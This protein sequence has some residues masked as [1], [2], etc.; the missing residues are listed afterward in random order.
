MA[1]KSTR[2]TL[3]KI[4]ETLIFKALTAGVFQPLRSFFKEMDLEWGE[5][6]SAYATRRNGRA[7][8]VLGPK[9]FDE[10][11]ENEGEAAEVVLHEIMHH[12][13]LHLHQLE[14]FAGR[15]Y[16]HRIQNIAMDAVI[17]AYLSSIKCA[18]FMERYYKDEEEYAF[19]RPGSEEF[20]MPYG[21]GG[22]LKKPVEQIDVDQYSSFWRFY[23]ELYR[24]EVKLEQSLS[25][26]QRH[27][28]DS[29]EDKN[30]QLLG[31]HGKPSPDQKQGQQKPEAGKQ[32]EEEKKES[33][34][35]GEEKKKQQQGSPDESGI[36]RSEDAEQILRD[37]GLKRASQKAKDNFA[38]VIKKIT[39]SVRKPGTVRTGS[40]QSRRIP[41]KLGRR[42]MVNVERGRDL[43]GRAEY[44]MREAMLLF[45]ISGSMDA[46]R[47]FVIDLAKALNRAEVKVRTAVWADG[48]QEVS[49]DEFIAGKFPD[50]GGGTTGEV[51]AEFIN[52]NKIPQAAII[53]DNA[54][55][56]IS[57]KIS[58]KIYLCLV[59]GA[60]IEGSFID[61]VHVPNC[62]VYHLETGG[63]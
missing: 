12:L 62:E 53:T 35:K 32:K 17:N 50:V 25:F 57:T 54:A 27:F 34:G 36:F 8:I 40:T 29:K 23:R 41:A 3:E 38:E 52:D 63:R 16:S 13:F 14:E 61:P 39:T 45:D 33:K 42:D 9:F 21:P 47:Q 51:V 60:W 10:N 19:L 1:Q 28:P 4:Q 26:F 37:L 6:Q 7:V 55:G 15:G 44:R 22:M 24:L 43:F 58:A 48:I 49:Y 5:A 31:G 2:F 56:S 20:C 46:Y 59:E 11:L 18:G 30:Q